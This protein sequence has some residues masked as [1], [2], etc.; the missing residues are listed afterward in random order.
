MIDDAK[1]RIRKL[2]ISIKVFSEKKER[3][4]PWPGQFSSQKSEQQHS[5]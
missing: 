5:V 4:E 2:E 1:E 3:D